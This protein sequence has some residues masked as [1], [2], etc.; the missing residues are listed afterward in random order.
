MKM[1]VGRPVAG[2][3]GAEATIAPL[4]FH[5]RRCASVT[6]PARHPFRESSSATTSGQVSSLDFSPCRE[7]EINIRYISHIRRYCSALRPR[8]PA[9]SQFRHSTGNMRFY[10]SPRH[11]LDLRLMHGSPSVRCICKHSTLGAIRH[12]LGNPVG[13]PMPNDH[14]LF[15]S[16]NI[17]RHLSHKK[18]EEKKERKQM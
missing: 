4:G 18:F 8:Y 2:A 11:Q 5:S 12:G 6:K 7:G 1:D 10:H 13:C 9:A 14:Q 3:L 17:S 15:R 16:L